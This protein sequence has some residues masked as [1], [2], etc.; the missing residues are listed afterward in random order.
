MATRRAALAL[1]ALPLLTL[2][3][4]GF[5]LR[6]APQFAFRTLYTGAPDSST[7]VTELKRTL[8]S[9]GTLQL[10]T[11][12]RQI[13]QAD[14]LLDLLNEQRER[15]VVALNS[16]GQVRELQLRL[17]VKFRLRAPNGR[18]LIPEVELLLSRDMSFSETQA[19]AKDAE[20]RLLY[21]DMQTDI[22]QQMMRR[23][24]AVRI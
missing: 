9:T 17:R 22:V 12:A 16:A 19:L 23:L 11:D 13:D 2:A 7:L 21:R 20:E 8:R 24:A 14:V 5:A 3:G 1:A 6:Q 4:C 15:V 18:E 10:I